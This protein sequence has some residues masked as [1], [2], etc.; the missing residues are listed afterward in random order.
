MAR[1][2]NKVMLIG[3]LGGDPEIKYSTNGTAIANFSIA[4]TENRKNS[5]GEW[6]D[7]TE[8]HKI[9]IFGKQAEF[10]KDYLKKGSKIY[11]EGR[12]QT[13]TWEDQ[14]N[15]RHYVTEVVGSNIMM[16]DAKSQDSSG[17]GVD[18]RKNQA[19][20]GTAKKT[21]ADSFPETDD[22]LPF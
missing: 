11:L 19:P 7:K 13:R 4:T 14:N 20:S 16:L 2:L 15:Q 9:V 8:W 5:A 1:G 12:L 17:D 22:D 18:S 3:N 6:E 21:P 10:C